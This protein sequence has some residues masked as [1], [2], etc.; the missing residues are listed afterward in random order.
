MTEKLVRLLQLASP[1]LPVGAYSYSQGLEAA[2]EAGV[3]RDGASAGRWIGGVLDHS[4]A[5]MEAPVFL[6]LCGAWAAGDAAGA[7]RWN[8]LFLASRETAEL[9]AETA[10][11]GYSLAQLLPRLDAGEV[12]LDEPSF[13][14]AF[15]FAVA[16]W[17]IDPHEALIGY[18]WSWL[19][20][21]VLA[22]VK[23]LPL[24]QTEGQLLLVS[25]GGRLDNVARRASRLDDDR[26]GGFVPGLALLSSRHETQYSR[27]FRS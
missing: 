2:I 17:R 13:P 4:L 24:G 23:A 16:A 21:Q 9:R 20:N 8:G 10:Q 7:A 19:E 18:L 27:L 15:A 22:A 25:L 11:M 12:P 1:A 5:P 3:V 26:I 14:A 6:R